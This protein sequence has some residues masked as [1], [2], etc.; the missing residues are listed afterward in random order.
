MVFGENEILPIKEKTCDTCRKQK[1]VPSFRNFFVDEKG[2]GKGSAEKGG[3]ERSFLGGEQSA[4]KRV[5]REK[6]RKEHPLGLPRRGKGEAIYFRTEI[7]G[8]GKEK[9][10]GE[11]KKKRQFVPIPKLPFLKKGGER[12]IN[13]GG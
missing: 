5:Y 1:I 3:K 8:E 7:P 2:K 13:L 12:K 4:E 10:G 9:V 6:K 11:K